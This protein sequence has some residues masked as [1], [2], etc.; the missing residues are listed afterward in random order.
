MC[1]NFR[2]HQSNVSPRLHIRQM[3]IYN[4]CNSACML[5]V[6][7]Y[8]AYHMALLANIRLSTF[9][10]DRY[11]CWPQTQLAWRTCL[12]VLP[13][14]WRTPRLCTPI[15]MVTSTISP[16]GSFIIQASRGCKA[17]WGGDCAIQDVG[18]LLG[19]SACTLLRRGG[20]QR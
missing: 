19:C 10:C 11:R 20:L 12:R 6:Q 16:V 8:S 3:H 17:L 4:T 2:P 7:Q 18:R 15:T 5:H 14:D 9:W 13:H 1:S